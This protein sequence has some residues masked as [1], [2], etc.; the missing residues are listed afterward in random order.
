M[1][2]KDDMAVNILVVWGRLW[3]LYRKLLPYPLEKESKI[4]V[5]SIFAETDVIAA[6]K[7][8]SQYNIAT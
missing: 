7:D 6:W 4:N 1:I 8:H 3:A 5:I 2:M